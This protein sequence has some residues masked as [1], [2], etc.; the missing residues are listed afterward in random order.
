LLDAHLA[1]ALVIRNPPP[2]G[3]PDPQITALERKAATIACDGPPIVHAQ[4]LP[5]AASWV[6]QFVVRLR[7]ISGD[8]NELSLA[9]FLRPFR[10][11]FVQ[12]RSHDDKE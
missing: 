3:I 6:A 9:R 5:A 2:T 4:P 8:F 11:G 10:A 12:S 1:S 7:S